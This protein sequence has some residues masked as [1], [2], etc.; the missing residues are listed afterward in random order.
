MVS[1]AAENLAIVASKARFSVSNMA[2]G[3]NLLNQ[4]FEKSWKLYDEQM[5]DIAEEASA[6]YEW[7]NQIV[8]AAEE[9]F[10]R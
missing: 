8:P 9:A 7:I 5:R 4:I 2:N 1:I 10:K 3:M 6:I